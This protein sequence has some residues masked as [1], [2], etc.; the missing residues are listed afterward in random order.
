MCLPLVTR[1]LC[2]HS[3]LSLAEAGLCQTM[4]QYSGQLWWPFRTALVPAE[5]WGNTVGFEGLLSHAW[6]GLGSYA[7][8]LLLAGFS[9]AVCGMM[10]GSVGGC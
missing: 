6:E 3:G 8:L 9:D 4:P 5:G 7:A 1:E 2:L 10:N